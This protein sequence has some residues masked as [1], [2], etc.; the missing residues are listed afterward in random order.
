MFKV[1]FILTRILKF[2]KIRGNDIK[3][4]KILHSFKYNL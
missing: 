1:F 3:E 4:C 2:A